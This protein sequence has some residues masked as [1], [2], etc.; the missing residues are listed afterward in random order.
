MNIQYC[1]D[2]H[3]EFSQNKK[4]LN[5]NPLLPKGE[6]LIL[7]GDIVPLNSWEKHN[8]FFDYVADHFKHTYWM[9]GNHE[10]YHF[11]LATKHAVFQEK[12]RNNVSLLNNS[13]VEIENKQLIFSTLWSKIS[14]E[15]EWLIEKR[16]NDFQLIKYK[17]FRLSSTNY[18]ILHEAASSFLQDAFK[19]NTTKQ[20]IVVTHHVPTFMHYPE[21]YR[22]SDI[23]QGFATELFETI[24][25][26]NANFWI[27][28]HHHQNMPNFKIGNTTLTTNQLGYVSHQEHH[29]FNREKLIKC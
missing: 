5:E 17:G 24:E 16:M 15:N 7:A 14:P 19:E 20:R 27:Y 12:I 9:P 18:N 1:S 11:D 6:I 3:L 26:S 10:Y 22:N 13:V 21:Q 2:L 29:L 25:K 8:D 28:G 4:W 23:N